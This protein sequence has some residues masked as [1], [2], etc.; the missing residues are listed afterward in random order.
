MAR[1]N[2]KSKTAEASASESTVALTSAV[3]PVTAATPSKK[4]AKPAATQEAAPAP[5]SSSSSEEVKSAKAKKTKAAA[6]ST[7]VAPIEVA[8]VVSAPIQVTVTEE[9]SSAEGETPV[10]EQSLEFLSKLQQLS[11]LISSLKTE[12]CS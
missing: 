7:D 12:Y 8:P 9:S 4:V 10:I 11:V 3:A 2:N 1:T 6:K 5:S